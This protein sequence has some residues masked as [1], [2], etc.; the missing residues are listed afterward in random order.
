MSGHNKW[1]TIKRKKGENDAA[2]GKIF[3]K[4]GRELTVAVKMGGP[5][6]AAN[7]KLKDVIAK[8]K[9]NNMPNDNIERSIKKAAGDGSNANY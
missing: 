9:A 5:D 8:C 6:P 4:F 7:S 3:T 2:R 1:S